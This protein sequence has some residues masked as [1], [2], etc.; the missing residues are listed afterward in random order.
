M[1]GA[2][3][4]GAIELG[5]IYSLVALGLVVSYR[6][7]GL[8]DLTTE[9]S[10]TLGAAVCA[11]QTTQGHPGVGLVLGTLAGACSGLVTGLLQ[12]RMKMQPI[13]AGI[14][15]MVGLYS[16]NLMAMGG[17]SNLTL[18]R[19]DTA[20]SWAEEAV[21]G[22]GSLLAGGVAA[23]AAALAL[24]LFFRTHGGLCLRAVGDNPTMVGAFALNWENGI[25]IGLFLAN[26]LIA[27]S[28]AL[29]VQYQQFCEITMGTGMVVLGLASLILGEVL[30][31]ASSLPGQLM[32]AVVGS[33]LYRI[34]M[35]GALAM[36]V[37]AAQLKLFSAILV[38]L[39]ISMPTLRQRMTF[40]RQRKANQPKEK[41]L[42]ESRL[43][44]QGQGETPC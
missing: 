14:V 40:S 32:A 33:V 9:G 21:P 36:D 13:L 5:L 20:F 12:T 28:G 15:T 23:L 18:L 41:G 2:A 7:L 37:P 11:L 44:Y 31:R 6:V 29:L 25:L 34:L 16:V 26:G 27:C 19:L 4:L 24:G 22:L 1:T 39:A 38:A 3:L 35:A 17:R 30:T 42:A 8:A 43:K 10:F